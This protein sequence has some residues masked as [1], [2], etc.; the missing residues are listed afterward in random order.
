LPQHPKPLDWIPSQSEIKTL[1]T[2][3]N[4]R[5]KA[6]LLTLYHTGLSEA[7]T[8][9]LTIE[10][11]KTLYTSGETQHIYFQK[12]REKST[13][14]TATCLSFEAIHDIGEMLAERGNPKEGFIFINP[15]TNKPLTTHGIQVALKE[16]VAKTFGAEK[17]KEFET[18]HLRDAY[19]SALISAGIVG[20]IKCL[21]M[22]H[23]TR[24]S[25]GKYAF[26][27]DD[28]KKAYD[29]LFP[30]VSINGLQARHDVQV[31]KAEVANIKT[32]YAETV[33]NLTQKLAKLEKENE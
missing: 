7:D 9:E 2:H 16:L 24:G 14:L 20:D 4:L 33:V 17:A 28:I 11:I 1:Y 30:H 10:S 18:R 29:R 3:A 15:S 21:M 8:A 31:M 19:N 27:P 5:N 6:L 13:E 23:T 22:G 12:Y 25:E 26:S 32:D